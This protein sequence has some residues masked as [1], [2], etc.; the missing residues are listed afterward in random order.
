MLK[1]V[2]RSQNNYVKRRKGQKNTNC[3]MPFKSRPNLDQTNSMVFNARR[4]NCLFQGGDLPRKA[5]EGFFWGN[6]ILN[7]VFRVVV[8]QMYATVKTHGTDHW[9]VRFT[10]WKV[11]SY[12]NKQSKTIAYI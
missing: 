10:V 2:A 7:T 9:P 4:D 3:V 1:T 8:K 11:H 6:E 12:L 5:L